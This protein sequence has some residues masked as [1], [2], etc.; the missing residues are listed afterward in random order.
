MAGI[1][2]HGIAVDFAIFDG[3]RRKISVQHDGDI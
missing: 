2:R 3:Q 1:A